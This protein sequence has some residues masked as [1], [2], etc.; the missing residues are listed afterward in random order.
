MNSAIFRGNKTSRR[1]EE[2]VRSLN[3]LILL[4]VALSWGSGFLFIK[5]MVEEVP[6]FASAFLRVFLALAFLLPAYRI[7]GHKTKIPREARL[8]VWSAGTF[9]FAFPFLFLFWGEKYISAGLTGVLQGTITLWTLLIASVF[10]REQEEI[11]K[12]KALG[13]FLSLGGLL[14][15][16]LPKIHFAGEVSELYGLIAVSLATLCYGIGANMNRYL[17]SKYEGLHLH[18]N[19]IHQLF[20]GGLILLVAWIS[21]EPLHSLGEILNNSRLLGSAL[22]LGIVSTGGAYLG[23]YHLIKTW[24][25]VRAISASYLVPL[26]AL[27]IEFLYNHSIPSLEEIL[28]VSFILSGVLTIQSKNLVAKFLKKT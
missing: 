9:M 19:L 25:S 4:L 20:S 3:F 23:L 24:G 5:I 8:G 12:E 28:G 11:T 22:F 14:I 21:T 6:P 2:Y 10:F 27:F 17:F 1:R 15:I 26:V 7:L 13:I 16:F 18:A